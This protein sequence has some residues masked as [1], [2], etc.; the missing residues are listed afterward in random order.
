MTTRFP[1]LIASSAFCWNELKLRG[2]L[3]NTLVIVTADHGEHLGDHLLFFHGC[4]LYLQLVHVPLVIVSPE[5][6]PADQVITE[7]VSLRDMPATIVHL[8]GLGGEEPFPGQSLARC[9]NRPD[10]ALPDQ[11]EPVLMETGKPLFLVND[12]REPAAKGPMK[13]LIAGGLHYIRSG[14][15]SEELYNLESDRKE[16]TNLAGLPGA[17]V[18][19]QSFRAALGW[20]LSK[21]PPSQGRAR[22]PFASRPN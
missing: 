20:M 8:L 13:A 6:V 2:V 9:W 22:G 11:V 12:G 5:V 18:T 15:G 1:I 7:P 17:A 3:E 10:G 21:H 14:D 19:L 4:S 16:Q